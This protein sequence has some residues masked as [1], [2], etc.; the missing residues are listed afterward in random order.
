[1][2]FG[3]ARMILRAALDPVIIRMCSRAIA[4][5]PGHYFQP[6]RMVPSR[7]LSLSMEDQI[8]RSH[9]TRGTRGDI[10]DSSGSA[11]ASM[12]SVC[13]RYARISPLSARPLAPRCPGHWKRREHSR[14]ALRKCIANDFNKATSFCNGAGAAK[15]SD[16]SFSVQKHSFVQLHRHL[17]VQVAAATRPR[18]RCLFLLMFRHRPPR[19]GGLRVEPAN[20][21]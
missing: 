18:D 3:A 21:H 2:L 14:S 15:F 8:L 6:W 16:S 9:L 1:M 5:Y 7:H 19:V 17:P 13:S 20:R 4:H 12:S 10:L 11:K